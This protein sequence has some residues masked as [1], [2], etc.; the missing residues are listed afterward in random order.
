M[1][2]SLPILALLCS[3]AVSHAWDLKPDPPAGKPWEPKAG[4]AVAL[5]DDEGY[6]FADAGGPFALVAL[7]GNA[8]G[9]YDLTAGGEPMRVDVGQ[10]W[11][12]LVREHLSPDGRVW[13]AAKALDK[14]VKVYDVSA[15]R[16]LPA[17]KLAAPLVQHGFTPDGRLVVVA[18]LGQERS[19]AL[20]DPATGKEVARWKID[21]A[22]FFLPGGATRLFA[23]SPGGKQLVVVGAKAVTVYAVPAGKPLAELPLPTPEKG[24]GASPPV[25][26]AFS[27]DGTELAVIAGKSARGAGVLK[28][29]NLT[30]GTSAEHPIDRPA[31][32]VGHDSPCLAPILAGGWVIDGT[33]LWVKGEL[34]SVPHPIGLPKPRLAVARDR[35]IGVVRPD[36]FARPPQKPTLGV[37]GG[38]GASSG[39]AKDGTLNGAQVVP[40]DERAGWGGAVA[41]Y[42]PP[43][44]PIPLL[45]SLRQ[46]AVGLTASLDGRRVFVEADVVKNA[47]SA[48]RTVL[49]VD[50]R[51]GES[52]A[53]TL[54]EKRVL[55]GEAATGDAVLTIGAN[56]PAGGAERLELYSADGKSLGAWVPHAD[57]GGVN[58][59]RSTIRYAAALSSTAALTVGNGRVTR[60]QLPEAKAVWTTVI[61]GANGGGLSPDG[62]VL[63]VPHTGG[64]RTLNV[65]SGGTLGNLKGGFIFNPLTAPS[66]VAVSGDG[67]RLAVTD[68]PPGGLTVG[69]WDLTTGERLT[70]LRPSGLSNSPPVRFLGPRFVLVGES[71]YDTTVGREVWKLK[72]MFGLTADAA[73]ADGRVWFAAGPQDRL[74]V[75]ADEFPAAELSAFLTRYEQTGTGTF[76]PGEGVKVVIDAPQ[77]PPGWEVKARTTARLLMGQLKLTDDPNAAVMVRVTYTTVPAT[78]VKLKW[79]GIENF[80]REETVNRFAV[81]SRTVVTRDGQQVWAGPPTKTEMRIKDWPAV[82]EITDDSKSGQE[83]FTRQVWDQAQYAVG[84]AFAASG[85][86]V[87]LANGTTWKLPGEATLTD[88]GLA[89]NWP[90]GQEPPP[91]GATVGGGG[92]PPPP[93]APPPV[94]VVAPASAWALW[95]AGGGCVGLVIAAGVV[96]LVVLLRGRGKKPAPER[97]RRRRD[98][99]DDDDDDDDRPRRRRRDDDDDRPRR[100]R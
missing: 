85:N 3:V 7:G 9:V 67:R 76:R 55:F 80:G 2:R 11:S 4:L 33:Q 63:F 29:W 6:A 34:R 26:V 41:A 30:D 28:V 60:W 68:T 98:D 73:P 59:L 23:V 64:I 18:G 20:Y 66:M 12:R 83:F 45:V 43:F 22:G 81:E 70:G 10:G 87:K 52:K 58:P 61:P 17:V 97:P 27:A 51:S 14:E 91:G 56:Q 62:K 71:V 57:R 82:N 21:P 92:V 96:L 77:A 13:A 74:T 24:P 1:K 84:V 39:V 44:A 78:P 50:A 37:L 89:M 38:A 65:A 79:Q 72:P 19:V 5:P 15:S 88:Q 46:A 69:V 49:A 99:D 95:L 93:V 32:V 42:V 94:P 53:F 90:A 36:P 8:R 35:L 86:G 40:T 16:A 100:R 47:E 31:A 25:G 48:R 75:R 54:P